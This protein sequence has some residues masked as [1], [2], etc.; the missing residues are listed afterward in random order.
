MYAMHSK[1]SNLMV[2]ARNV[3]PISNLK[4]TTLNV[5]LKNSHALIVNIEQMMVHAKLAKIT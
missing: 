1:F 3:V 4:I 2:N 5:K